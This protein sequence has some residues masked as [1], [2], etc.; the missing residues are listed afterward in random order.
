MARSRLQ[1]FV[2]IVLLAAAAYT[3]AV[4]YG[5]S[6]TRFFTVD[7]YQYGHATWLVGQ[8]RLPYVDFFEHHF[9]LSYV[10][11]APLFA[12]VDD[13]V[14]SALRLRRIVFAYWLIVAVL[15]AVACHA[16]TRNRL[17]AISTGFLPL[18][19]G[20][21]LMSAVDYRAD[22][23]AAVYF[24]ACLVLLEWNRRLGSRALSIVCGLLAVIAAGMTQKM[25]FFAGGTLGVML[26]SDALAR[27]RGS[28]RLP[29]V[30]RPAAFLLSGALLAVLCV[31]VAA[32]LGMLPAGIEA[33]LVQAAQHERVYEPFSVFEKGYV[34]PFWSRTWPTTLPTLLFAAV[35][36][37][38]RDGRFWL[39]P[40]LVSVVGLSSMAAPY[41]YNF[42]FLC[43]LLVVAAVRGFARCVEAMESRVAELKD[44]AALLYLLPIALLSSQLGFVSGAST[45]EHQLRV[46][47]RIEKY[48]EPSDAV[49]DD[50][51]GAM[52]SPDASY[53]FHHGAAH[54]EMFRDYFETRL[55][56]D[57]RRSQALFWIWDMRLRGLPK[58]ARDYLH[59]HYV[60][61][62]DGLHVL[63]TR[64]PMTG[65]ERQRFVFD[66]VRPG[67]YRVHRSRRG[68]RA[69]G[70]TRDH[71][72]LVDG[73]PVVGDRLQL[74]VGEHV[75]EVLPG[76]PEYLLTPVDSS[77]F[78]PDPA[79]ARYSMMFEYREPKETRIRTYVSMAE[80][81]E[82]A[83]ADGL[84]RAGPG[85]SIDQQPGSVLRYRV[86]VPEEPRLRGHARLLGDL[87]PPEAT[88]RLVVSI[89]SPGL[90][91]TLVSQGLTEPMRNPGLRIDSNLA[92]YAG[93]SAEV[94]ISFQAAAD[95]RSHIRWTGLRIDGLDEQ[96][97]AEVD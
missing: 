44:A 77:F 48:G 54:R 82:E 14:A 49:I 88:G 46:L 70:S 13:F 29:F 72:L 45:N 59:R 94:T 76:S 91:N 7:E 11:H 15:A 55:V 23:L 53:Y 95:P 47:S 67:E 58:Q 71:D 87:A 5:F 78:D 57:Y 85:G 24:A 3:F 33:T 35:F 73:R 31:G 52:F 86:E 27:R 4:V 62:G 63:G 56:E 37:A 41:P 6:Q 10:L 17:A 36:L 1:L 75:V 64:T 19:F 65:A 74:G 60:H 80:H 81:L 9:P 92:R 96:A 38:S 97:L 40:A 2:G 68:P 83:A 12:N 34:A 8:G 30:A 21:G 93:R 25:A 79:P 42:V 22:N 50:A 18:C 61:G 66:V 84:A 69:S 32:A 51:G 39:I 16:V 89:E 90:R 20:F 28:D 43:W 26:V